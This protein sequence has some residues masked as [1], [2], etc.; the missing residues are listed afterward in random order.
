MHAVTEFR[1]E[2]VLG[3]ESGVRMILAQR[4]AARRQDPRVE[5][6]GERAGPHRPGRG[7]R[8]GGDGLPAPRLPLAEPRVAFVNPNRPLRRALQ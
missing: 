7:S 1:I 4:S 2:H 3:S 5:V 6:V 8:A